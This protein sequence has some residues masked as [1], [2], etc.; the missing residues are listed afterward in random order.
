MII[1]IIT[2]APEKFFSLI[3]MIIIISETTNSVA[4]LPSC[5]KGVYR[6]LA[7]FHFFAGSG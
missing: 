5:K 7:D 2:P 6:F 1:I 3:I 4:Y